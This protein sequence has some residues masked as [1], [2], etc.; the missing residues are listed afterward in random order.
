MKT[1]TL[2]GVC[3]ALCS[4]HMGTMH[5]KIMELVTQETIFSEAVRSPDKDYPDLKIPV[6]YLPKRLR[7]YNKSVPKW[8]H[9][10]PDDMPKRLE[11][12][13][14]VF[15]R[16]VLHIHYK[17]ADVLAQEWYDKAKWFYIQGEKDSAMWHLG[18]A[19]HLIQDVTVP[20]HVKVAS[21]LVDAWNVL[22][23][24]SPNHSTFERRAEQLF[25]PQ[26]AQAV[27]VSDI[28]Q[29]VRDI[30]E[31]VRPDMKLCDGVDVPILRL[32]FPC[33]REDYDGCAKRSAA[34]AVK[35]TAWVIYSFFED[36]K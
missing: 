34:R 24:E 36:V 12:A 14:D 3:V 26:Q 1:L 29:L 10:Y 7:K 5:S 21:G 27:Y 13:M 16:E 32:F 17:Y 8:E 19:C 18:R 31:E 28:K 9:A 22:N 33:L 15:C 30:A 11:N 2:L 20:M 6:E 25:L 35:Y 23:D 4:A